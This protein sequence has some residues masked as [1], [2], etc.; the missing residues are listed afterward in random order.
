MIALP[1]WPDPKWIDKIAKI[2]DERQVRVRLPDGLVIEPVDA[3]E[4]S[5]ECL[6]DHYSDGEDQPEGVVYFI[7]APKYNRVKIGYTTNVYR[8]FHTIKTSSPEHLRLIAVEPGQ[9]ADEAAYHKR[10]NAH[11]L[12]GEWF[13]LSPEIEDEVRSIR[14]RMDPIAPEDE[15]TIAELAELIRQGK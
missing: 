14:A 2:C 12:S 7:A 1:G 11:R 13:E 4:L 3:P 8:R 10:F 5:H 9:A 15:P 6:L